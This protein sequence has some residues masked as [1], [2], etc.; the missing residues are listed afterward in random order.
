MIL[1]FRIEIVKTSAWKTCKIKKRIINLFYLSLP[2][3]PKKG[4]LNIKDIKKSEYMIC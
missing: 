4:M 3:L 2:E 1:K